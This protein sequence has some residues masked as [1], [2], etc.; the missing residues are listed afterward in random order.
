MVVLAGLAYALL[1]ATVVGLDREVRWDEVTYL[2][3]V[4]PGQ[5]DVWFGP[6]RARGMTVVLLPVAL[7][8]APL[9]LLRGWLVAVHAVA[10]VLAFRPWARVAGWTGGAAAA[11]AAVGWVP[12]YFAVEGYPNLLAAFAAVAA[13]GHSLAWVRRPAQ[14]PTRTLRW[15][16][17]RLDADL[18]AAALAIAVI[19]WLRPTE[20][21]WTA[22]AL[23]PVVVV[24]AGWR[25][26]R[27][28][29]AYAAGGFVGW[30]PWLIEAIVRFGGPLARIDAARATSASGA[31]RNSLIQYLNLIEGPVRRVV[32]DPVLTAPAL[33]LLV[34]A[35]VLA[36]IGLLARAGA[37]DGPGRPPGDPPGRPPG[38]PPDAPP[39][40]LSSAGPDALSSAG[41]D[42]PPDAPRSAGPDAG[43]RRAA[44]L[45]GA[46][47]GAALVT[48]Y[49][50]LNAGI[51][52]RYVL[53][54]LLLATLPVG[55]G[56]AVLVAASWRARRRIV[57][58]P[59]LGMLAVLA[60]VTVGWQL[61]LAAHNAEQIAPL[62]ARPVALGAALAEAADGA[63][64]AFVSNAQWPEIQ[65]HSGCLGEVLDVANPLLQC[66]DAR[67]DLAALAA[68]GH[69]VFVFGRDEPPF[70]P[71]VAGWPT[72]PL[73]DVPGGWWLHERPAGLGPDDPPTI[74]APEDSTTPCPPS[75]AP[76]TDD[77]DLT[78]RWTR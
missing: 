65:W 63:P 54:G 69:R 67:R 57:G 74:P 47:T 5:P 49:L 37:A 71:A 36:L 77:A 26:W 72:T 33:A 64:C 20:S 1:A 70:S 34:G 27:L 58:I 76:D 38:D 39:D 42:A 78:F 53:P 22:A 12:L 4:T 17:G 41:P 52:L 51:N 61:T 40:A 10:L 31:S 2:A 44:A 60:V 9:T 55:A 75:R 15:T 24:A 48:P 6:Q 11:L 7:L 43:P 45:T 46:F 13:A 32:S 28:L 59:A 18:V 25:S 14:E 19:A 62:Q 73:P 30:L 50:V 56:V 68:Q 66:H 29:A 23:T 16:G 3:Q 21:V 8:G 35:G